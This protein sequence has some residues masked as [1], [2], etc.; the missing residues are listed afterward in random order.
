MFVFTKNI[1]KHIIETKHFRG[2]NRMSHIFYICPFLNK[3]VT[4]AN[5]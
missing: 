2:K 3:F 1:G 5:I 4:K